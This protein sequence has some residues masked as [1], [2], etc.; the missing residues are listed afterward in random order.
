MRE[1]DAT[2]RRCSKVQVRSNKPIGFFRLPLLEV[3]MPD[4]V[5]ELNGHGSQKPNPRLRA[6]EG[7]ERSNLASSL[8]LFFAV[9]SSST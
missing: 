1:K 7:R 8:R 3:K 6:G 4:T 2:R 5:R 9:L